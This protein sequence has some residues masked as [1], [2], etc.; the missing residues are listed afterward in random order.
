MVNIEF[1]WFEDLGGGRSRRRGRSIYPT[2]EARD[3]L[4][5]KLPP[6]KG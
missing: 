6:A 1:L 4:L 5:R 3:A 2:V